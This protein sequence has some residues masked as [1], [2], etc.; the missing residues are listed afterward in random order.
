MTIFKKPAIL[1]SLLLVLTFVNGMWGSTDKA[2][3]DD[4]AVE[5]R[6]CICPLDH[7]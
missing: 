7:G 3:T 1:I 6:I 5:S 4:E 2:G